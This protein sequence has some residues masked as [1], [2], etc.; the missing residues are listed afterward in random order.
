MRTHSRNH[1]KHSHYDMNSHRLNVQ[2][3]PFNKIIMMDEKRGQCFNY[4]VW[5]GENWKYFGWSE[6]KH[7]KCT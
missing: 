1:M 3:I 5:D 7:I 4:C 2:F 6:I